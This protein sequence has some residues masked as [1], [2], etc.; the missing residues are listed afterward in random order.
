MLFLGAK[1]PLE[2][3]RVSQSVS[4]Q[5]VFNSIILQLYGEKMIGTKLIGT[6]WYRIHIWNALFLDI[7]SIQK[8]LGEW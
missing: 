6:E 4:N 8:L 3:A 7:L 2:I 1:A 5:K